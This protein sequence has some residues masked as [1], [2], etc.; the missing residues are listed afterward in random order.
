M[1]PGPASDPSRLLKQADSGLQ[2][3]FSVIDVLDLQRLGQISSCA[4]VVNRSSPWS[5][6]QKLSKTCSA[7]PAMSCLTCLLGGLQSSLR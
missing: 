6:T 3:T 2:P 4:E 1:N 5:H 7:S